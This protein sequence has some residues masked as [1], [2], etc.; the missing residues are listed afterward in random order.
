MCALGPVAEL[1]HR[2]QDVDSCSSGSD[3]GG[4]GLP[5]S[6]SL[7][8]ACSLRLDDCMKNSL[9]TVG[10]EEKRERVSE[11]YQS[12]REREMERKARG[13]CITSTT[14]KTLEPGTGNQLLTNSARLS[15]SPSVG[16]LS[17][18]AAAA[19]ADTLFMYPALNERER[20]RDTSECTGGTILA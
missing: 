7:L 15:P 18:S 9:F 16:L 1:G 6:S 14:R 5:F 4:G 12:Q 11:H 10:K 13:N 3:D 19:A 8:I 17:S 20:E 2:D